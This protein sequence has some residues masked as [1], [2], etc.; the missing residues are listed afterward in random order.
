M[1]MVWHNDE[2]TQFYIAK[3]GWQFVPH[4]LGNQ[5]KFV[6]RHFTVCN[7]AKQAFAFVGNYRNE[8]RTREGVIVSLQS[9][10]MTVMDFG[11]EFHNGIITITVGT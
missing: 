10:G 1:D 9:D 7:F 6:L 8:I 5:T 11:V 3:T 2:R 4:L